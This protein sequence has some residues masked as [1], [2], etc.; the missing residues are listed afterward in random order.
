[1]AFYSIEY[2]GKALKRKGITLLNHFHFFDHNK[3]FFKLEIKLFC[4]VALC[5]KEE[6]AVGSEM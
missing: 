5:N 4:L 6:L 2:L 1:M 3:E